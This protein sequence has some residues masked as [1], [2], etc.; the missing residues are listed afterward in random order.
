MTHDANVVQ[1]WEGKGDGIQLILG[2]GMQVNQVYSLF[3]SWATTVV[4]PMDP[5]GMSGTLHQLPVPK[6]QIAFSM[7]ACWV[8]SGCPSLVMS[9]AWSVGHPA[10]L[11]LFRRDPTRF[12]TTFWDGLAPLPSW[13]IDRLD[14]ALAWL[15]GAPSRPFP[16]P[17]T[18]WCHADEDGVISLST[19]RQWI[20]HQATELTIIPHHGHTSW[21]QTEAAH[22]VVSG[23]LAAIP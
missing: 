15:D 18:Q 4:I 20:G 11:R 22:R 19:V 12:M 6:C 7:G 5:M 3:Q 21:W 14:G 8:R 2:W 10:T 1:G 17:P 9:G 16:Q 13:P 23:F